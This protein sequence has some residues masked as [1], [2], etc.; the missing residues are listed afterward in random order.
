MTGVSASSRMLSQEL[1]KAYPLEAVQ[2]TEFRENGFIKL[3]GVFSAEELES[4]A[5]LIS[6]VV[7]GEDLNEVTLAERSSYFQA[8]IQ[9]QNLWTR[10]PALRAFILN[11]RCARIAAELLGVDGIRLW[12]DQALFKEVGGG[13]TPWHADQFFW[14][15]SSM[16]S[17]TAWIP[18]QSTS[19]EAGA[20]QFAAGSHRDDHGRKYGISDEGETAIAKSLGHAGM[21]VISES[22]DLGDVSF[23]YGW[24]FHRAEG[25]RTSAPREAMTMIYMDE[26]MRVA[27]PINVFQAHD[28]KTWAPGCE[29]GE[30]IDSE[31]NPILYSRDG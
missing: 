25:N 8:F 23:H 9:I 4:F 24:T 10:H 5:P 12:H 3:P 17:I 15:M 28:Q 18:L 19:V 14:P 22:Y 29:V 2:I 30:K 21:E 31:I 13:I 27:E 1:D 7:E 6:A 16:L 26:A 11:R 20:L